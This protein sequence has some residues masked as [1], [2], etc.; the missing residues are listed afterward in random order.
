MLI[1][2][3]HLHTRAGHAC[4]LSSTMLPKSRMARHFCRCEISSPAL[5]QAIPDARDGVSSLLS[6][7]GP[8]GPF[9]IGETSDLLHSWCT[10]VT[11][12]R[13]GMMCLPLAWRSHTSFRDT[14]FK[15]T[16]C[17]RTIKIQN[18]DSNEITAM[19]CNGYGWP[20]S[21]SSARRGCDHI[22][23]ECLH[24]AHESMSTSTGPFRCA[25]RLKTNP[26]WKQSKN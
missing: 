3:L 17:T 18:M 5:P 22:S 19:D 7:Y 9:E 11:F 4:C 25:A 26:L 13:L 15:S 20:F 10:R 23:S 6:W 1:L 21:L 14:S 2:A 16:M 24:R 12:R 8:S